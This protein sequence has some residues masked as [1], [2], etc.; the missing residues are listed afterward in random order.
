[1]GYKIGR[2][3]WRLWRAGSGLQHKNG[4]QLVEAAGDPTPSGVQDFLSRLGC[5][6]PVAATLHCGFA[7]PDMRIPGQVGQAFRFHVVK[8]ATLRGGVARPRPAL[9]VGT[10]GECLPQ[11]GHSGQTQFP[12]RQRQASAASM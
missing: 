4:W 2:W 10:L 8:L 1:M 9:T 5:K 7:M 11:L 6:W 3:V 12:Q